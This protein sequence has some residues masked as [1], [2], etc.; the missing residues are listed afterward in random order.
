MKT[1]R[2]YMHKQAI[3]L[4]NGEGP[5]PAITRGLSEAECD[6]VTTHSINGALTLLRNGHAN[7]LIA[8]AQAGAIP[9][10]TLLREWQLSAQPCSPP[11]LTLIFDREGNDIYTAVQALQLGAR[12]YLL[13]SDPE[14]QREL[15]ARLLIERLTTSDHPSSAFAAL[16]NVS[17]SNLHYEWDP[18]VYVIRAEGSYIRLSRTEGRIFGLLHT[19]LGTAV[20]LRELTE[21]ALLETGLDEAGGAERLRP[22]MMRLRRKLTVQ[23][24]LANRIISVRGTGYMLT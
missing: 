1:E 23:P 19:R 8:E 11:P 21:Q 13:A 18:A 17:R 16:P 4:C 10:L 15:T 9:L 12:D 5:D 6:V 22:H 2:I 20:T 24:G 3:Y 7:V 14:P